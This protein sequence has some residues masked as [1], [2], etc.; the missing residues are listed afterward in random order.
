[1]RY[2]YIF[3]GVAIVIFIFWI[4]QIIFMWEMLRIEN[5]L[6]EWMDTHWGSVAARICVGII[7][8]LIM[9][10]FILEL[11]GRA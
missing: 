6:F 3:I 8:A 7:C 1:M 10:C 11:L 5:K 9:V 2:S 4:Y